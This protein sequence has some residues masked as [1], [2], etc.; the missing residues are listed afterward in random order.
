MYYYLLLLLL[1]SWFKGFPIRYQV[2]SWHCQPCCNVKNFYDFCK[3]FLDMFYEIHVFDIFVLVSGLAWE[4]SRFF[5]KSSPGLD[6]LLRSVKSVEM[7]ELPTQSVSVI[8]KCLFFLCC[9]FEKVISRIFPFVNPFCNVEYVHDKFAI[10][11]LIW[12]KDN[13][14]TLTVW[15]CQCV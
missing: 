1:C 14:K 7:F 11:F 10:H 8:H 9:C 2:S 15:R 4:F 12:T 6:H 13:L 3:A 5:K